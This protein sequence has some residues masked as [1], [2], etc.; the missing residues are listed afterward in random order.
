MKFS[1]FS[2]S[3]L[4]ETWLSIDSLIQNIH[5]HL[6]IPKPRQISPGFN[7]WLIQQF[8]QDC[9]TLCASEKTPGEHHVT[10]QTLGDAQRLKSHC[11]YRIRGIN[12]MGNTGSLRWNGLLESQQHSAITWKS[13]EHFGISW[14]TMKQ[15]WAGFCIQQCKSEKEPQVAKGVLW[16]TS[17]QGN[18]HPF[19]K[20]LHG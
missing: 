13:P 6:L 14:W 10:G 11:N 18:I 5:K 12:T 20:S 9:K 1:K 4:A 17:Q 3:S 8:G 19:N 16:Q 15:D 2:F 7:L